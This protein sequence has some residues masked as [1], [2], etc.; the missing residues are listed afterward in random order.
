MASVQLSDSSGFDWNSED[1]SV[2]WKGQF[3]GPLSKVLYH[4]HPHFQA[5]E[6]SLSYVELLL[7]KVL[8]K[9]TA[10][11]A[12]TTVADVEV[13]HRPFFSFNLRYTEIST[14]QESFKSLCSFSDWPKFQHSYN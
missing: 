9:I 3:V 13:R 1:I 7:I 6:E 8:A 4:S 11:P 14:N 2:K 5:D 10:K 12:P